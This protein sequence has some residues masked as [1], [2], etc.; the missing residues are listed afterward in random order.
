[1]VVVVVGVPSAAPALPTA[2]P[3]LGASSSTR[4]E[5]STSG[6]RRPPQWMSSA[7][8]LPQ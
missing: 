8:R 7:M 1:M 3:R 2:V 5:A 6:T 4:A